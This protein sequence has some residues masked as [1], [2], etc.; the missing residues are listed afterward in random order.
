[1]KHSGSGHDNGHQPESGKSVNNDLRLIAEKRLREQRGVNEEED[2]N[3]LVEELS[4]HKLE[5]EIQNEELRK[6]QGDLRVAYDRYAVLYE[7]APVAFLTLSTK[8]NILNCNRA[9]SKLFEVPAQQIIGRRL[10]DFVAP[11]SQDDLHLHHYSLI[12]DSRTQSTSLI[13]KTKGNQSKTVLLD[14][15]LDRQLNPGELSW[16]ASLTD[17][18]D[19]KRLE[20]E[21]TSLNRELEERVEARAQQYLTSRQET[22]AVLNAA[23]DPI[24]TIDGEYLIQSINRATLRVFGYAEDELLGAS[25]MKLLTDT[26]ALVFRRALADCARELIGQA[27][28]VRR[29]L[30]CKDKSGEQIPV[31]TALARVDEEEHFMIIF[32]DLREKRRLE[33]EVMQVAEDERS[34][35]SRELHDSLGQELAAMSLDTRVIA[36]DLAQTDEAA[37]SK[38]MGFSEKLQQC[39][40]DLRGIIFDLGPMEVSDGGLVDAL[41]AL[42]RNFPENEGI[43]CSFHHSHSEQI[44]NLPHETEIQLLR[45]AQE[46]VHNARKHSQAKQIVVRLSGKEDSIELQI[47]D[48]G[49]GLPVSKRPYLSGQGLR[50]MEYRCSLIGGALNISNFSPNGTRIACCIDQAPDK[51]THGNQ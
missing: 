21:L 46:A 40:A 34:R 2:L 13:L 16:F 5:L 35:I 51:G 36:E 20:T 41:E 17:I 26:G 37:S 4:I 45:I 22:L 3:G 28:K 42:V 38:F 12:N 9:A 27:P 14:S 15:E 6:I 33:W 32:Q 48:D 44:G 25:L 8:G 7:R 29:E 31:E 39:V 43:K 1:M 30:R 23:A 49:L 50:I 10:H 19:Q 47:I 24:I 18:S 11:D